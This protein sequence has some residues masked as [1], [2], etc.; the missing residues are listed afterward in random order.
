MIVGASDL[1]ITIMVQ[2]VLFNLSPQITF[3]FA[4][5]TYTVLN[6]VRP[7]SVLVNQDEDS[8]EISSDEEIESDDTN[9]LDT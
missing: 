6:L 9:R 2:F 7:V 8:V 4:G 1:F 3:K 5:N